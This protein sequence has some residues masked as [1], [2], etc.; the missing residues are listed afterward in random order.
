ASIDDIPN[1]GRDDDSESDTTTPVSF[2][3]APHLQPVIA[4]KTGAFDTGHAASW[5]VNVTNSGTVASTGTTT[6]FINVQNSGGGRGWSGSGS[7]WTCSNSSTCSTSAAPAAGA[8][9]PALTI[10][11]TGNPTADDADGGYLEA[12]ASID[13][14]PNGGR[15]DDSESESDAP[16]VSTGSAGPEVVIGLSGPSKPIASGGTA[17]YTATVLN[18]GSATATGTTTVDVSS[19][20]RFTGGTGSGWTCSVSGDACTTSSSVKSTSSLPALKLSTKASSSGDAWLGSAPLMF[21]QVSNASDGDSRDNSAAL[22][23]PMIQPPV[24]LV[25]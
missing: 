2:G 15:D 18:R 8:T 17:T 9:L 6:V 4:A 14:I 21:L 3:V 7:G 11:L 13:D 1:G 22:G 12:I 19:G 25:A 23:T 10:T 16:V 20:Y 5:S 24:D